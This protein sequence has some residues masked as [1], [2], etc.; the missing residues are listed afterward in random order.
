MKKTEIVVRFIYA[1]ILMLLI[2]GI[3]SPNT[4]ASS[5]PPKPPAT[6]TP[7]GNSTPGTT[8]PATACKQTHKPL[9]ALNANNGNDFTASPY[10]SL[11]FYVP[12]NQ[13]DVKHAEFI[14]LDAQERTTI[15][16]TTVKLAHQ[17]GLIKITLPSK[18]KKMLQPNQNYRWY[19]MLNCQGSKN[20]EPDAVID[21]WIQR[22]VIT[23]N[24]ANNQVDKLSKYI[25]F[26]KNN[27][28][29]DAIND[30]AELHFKYPSDVKIQAAWT[31]LLQQLDKKW[32]A[33][34]Q[35]VNT[36]IVSNQE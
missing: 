3:K 6:G 1:G 2:A 18:S 20:D 14:L 33:P 35:L 25:F 28:W 19:L 11:W 12:Y 23:I 32:I 31:N 36:A 24:L 13:D 15:Y 8:R 21:G 22:K 34:E 17:P 30:V 10:P 5:P 9:T 16:Q 4:Y 29:Y 26:S 27:L 7:K